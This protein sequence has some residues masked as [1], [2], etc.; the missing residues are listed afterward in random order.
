MLATQI[1]KENIQI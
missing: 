1:I